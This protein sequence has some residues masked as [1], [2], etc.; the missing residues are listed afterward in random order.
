MFVCALSGTDREGHFAPRRSHRAAEAESRLQ[1]SRASR[2]DG[3]GI[4]SCARSMRSAVLT[5]WCMRAGAG[6]CQAGHAHRPR[7][8][9]KHDGEGGRECC[10]GGACFH[11]GLDRPAV[12]VQPDRTQ[13]RTGSCSLCA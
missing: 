9:W 10:G 12:R 13:G 2:R 6:V 11:H 4:F 7:H 3:A 8:H 5:Q 1:P